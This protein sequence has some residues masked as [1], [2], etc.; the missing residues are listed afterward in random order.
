M[1]AS[2]N[3]K[4]NM[5]GMVI[6]VALH[7]LILLGLFF[8]GISVTPPDPPL[9]EGMEIDFGFSDEGMG[10]EIMSVPAGP[11][12]SENASDVQ[13][14][15]TPQET[16]QDVI[17]SQNS[18]DVIK[19]AKPNTK[20]ITNVKPV[21]NPK[22]KINQGALMPGQKQTG[23]QGTG[24][25]PGNEGRLDG[26]PNGGKGG[27]GNNPNGIGTGTGPVRPGS[28][29]VK[30]EGRTYISAPSFTYNEQEDGIV[31]VKVTVDRNGNVVSATTDGVKGSTTTN[32]TLHSLAISNA[33]KYRFNAKSD[34]APEQIGYITYVF[35]RN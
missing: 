22:P 34:A 2:S 31:V 10:N 24:T 27:S 8:I 29:Q 6:T 5:I 20:P 18:D 7:G 30:M 15:A 19:A 1:Q 35:N 28:P 14:K 9:P 25:K 32:R 4:D 23:G 33:R 21:E 16:P 3:S 26:I 12:V 17:T 13:V 11:V